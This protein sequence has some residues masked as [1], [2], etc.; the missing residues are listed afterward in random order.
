MLNMMTIQTDVGPRDVAVLAK[1]RGLAL[2]DLMPMFTPPF[3]SRGKRKRY[4]VTH[5]RSGLCV[6][7]GMTGDAARTNSLRRAKRLL[8]ELAPIAYWHASAE[9]LRAI[10]APFDSRIAMAI[11]RGLA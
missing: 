5:I 3:Q 10:R 1:S 6:S 4:S 8:H 11:K 7:C 2:L 9:A